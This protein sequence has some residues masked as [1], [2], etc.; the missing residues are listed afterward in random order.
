VLGAMSQ[1]LSTSQVIGVVGPIEVGDAQRYVNGFRAG[2][3]AHDPKPTVAVTYTGSFGDIVLAAEAAQGHVAAG[4]DVLTGTGEMVVGA[5]SVAQEKGALWFG[6]Q[7]SQASL[8]PGIVVASQIYRWEVLL[9]PIIA[10]IDAGTPQGRGLVADLANGGL[11]I[12]HNP[13]FALPPEV[14][15]KADEVTAQIITGALA[16]PRT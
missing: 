6:T 5:V 10:D 12:E 4:A 1:M 3:Q 14:K 8:A 7:A 11:V 9:R 16:V 15:L 13:A 2:A